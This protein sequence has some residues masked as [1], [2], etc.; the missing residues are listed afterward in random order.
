MPQPDQASLDKVLAHLDSNLDA[1]VERLFTFLRLPSIS[2]DPAYKQDCA[3]AAE[4][5]KADIATIG[6][7]ASVRPTRGHPV[8][9]GHAKQGAG[10]PHMLFYG[11]YDVQPVDPL[12]LWHN[13]PFE[14]R[15]VEVEPGRK[16]ILARGACDDKGQA[17]TFVE[18]C[19]AWKAVTGSLPI[20]LTLL[21][22]GEEECGSINLPAFVEANK[23]ELK[24]D[25]ALV[26][27][28][29][30]WDR[31]TPAITSTLRG[32]VYEEVTIKAADRDLHSGVFGGGA[33]NPINILTKI[34]G[35]LRNEDGRILLPGFYD[36]VHELP[37][38]LKAD[39]A[40]LNLTPEEFLGQIGLSV[41]VG[42]KGRLLIEMVQSRP[43]FDINGIWGGYEGEGSKTVIP[44][45]ASAKVSFRLVGDQDPQKISAAF[46][47]YVRERL[48][49]D[50]KA[51]FIHHASS[52][53]IAL[54]GDSPLLMKARDALLSEWGKPPV[55][56]GSGGSVPIVGDFKRT[57]G[58]DSLLVGFG[59]DDDRVHS[60]NEKYD[61]SSFHHGMRSWARIL[62]ALAA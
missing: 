39:W 21:I 14:P 62:G 56:I 49:A 36:G 13:P 51:E 58:I 17:M 28:T 6:F 1:A 24:A 7:E 34:L 22:E 10:R 15:L 12:S 4:H 38:Q 27:D 5:L 18:A 42:E 8:V 35:G 54:P 23:T 31:K 50:C 57:L 3:K 41:P 53:A 46:E 16:V 20:D 9:M 60:P 26:C 37:S 25:A 40:A 33:A 55:T 32:M 30:M 47:A 11:H 59:L 45:E 29:G 2:T 61:L 43:T 19:R 44:A 48:P 52:K